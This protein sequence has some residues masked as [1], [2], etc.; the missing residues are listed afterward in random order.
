MLY[1]RT[2]KTTVRGSGI[3]L[4]SGEHTEFTILPAPPDSG[5]V[6][7]RTDVTPSVE[8]PARADFVTNTRLA[9]TLGRNGIAIQTVEHMVAALYGLGV[10]NARVLI[11]GPEVPILDGSAQRFVDLIREAGGTV[12]QRRPKRF[13]VVRKTIHVNDPDGKKFARLEPASSFRLACTIDFDHPL[14][15]HQHFE[16]TFSDTAF[17]REIARA[18]T[19]GFG[20]DVDAMHKAG[21]AKGGSLENAVVIDDFSIRNAE[22][23]RYPDEFVRHKLLDAIGD[24]ALLG[25]PIIGRYVGHRS[26]HSLNTTLAGRLLEDQRAYEI[27][28]FRQRREV[29]TQ[30]LEL[31]T[32]RIG[33]LQP[34]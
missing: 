15:S 16:M 27:V 32:F 3:G 19:F 18:R 4:H 11:D 8:I 14:L 24:L 25:V 33:G 29:Q 30:K 5:I 12:A 9:T 17:V 28:E 10:D 21:L 1:Q 20:K 34:A 26:G 7:E 31:P 23:L 13:L 6:F 22:G 2:V